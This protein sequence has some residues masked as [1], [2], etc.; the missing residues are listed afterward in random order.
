MAY[1][2]AT[3]SAEGGASVAAHAKMVA[4]EQLRK[5]SGASKQYGKD[6][7]AKNEERDINRVAE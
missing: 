7:P 1:S 3:K 6:L 2:R 4:S 5:C